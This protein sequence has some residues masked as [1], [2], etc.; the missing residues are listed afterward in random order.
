MKDD[1]P[2]SLARLEAEAKRAGAVAGAGAK[3]SW[4]SREVRR[5]GCLFRGAA[6]MII[7][8]GKAGADGG[9]ENPEEVAGTAGGMVAGLKGGRAAD[10]AES[11][12]IAGVLIIGWNGKG[13]K[14]KGGGGMAVGA[15]VG[16]KAAPAV[17]LA[18]A[19]AAA[20]GA[21]GRAG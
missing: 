8:E 18:A 20:A 7:G 12:T 3:D 5:G 4:V 21:V 17:I 11:G 13:G 9:K 1:S 16:T 2:A 15:E 6:P 19:A 10:E 14:Q